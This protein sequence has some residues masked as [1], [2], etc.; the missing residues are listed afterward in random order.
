MLPFAL[1]LAMGR[2]FGGCLFRT[3]G[4]GRQGE[5]LGA[6]SPR[7]RLEYDPTSLRPLEPWFDKTWPPGEVELVK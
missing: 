3:H 5:E 2:R 4:P 6:D 7:Q 1:A